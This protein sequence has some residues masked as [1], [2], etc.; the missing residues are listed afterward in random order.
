MSATST[1]SEATAAE[2]HQSR[3]TKYGLLMAALTNVQYSKQDIKIL[4][5]DPE[6]T[7]TDIRQLFGVLR[8]RFLDVVWDCK[9]LELWT[10]RAS[11][12]GIEYMKYVSEE[13]GSGSSSLAVFLSRAGRAVEDR[14]GWEGVD[15][16]GDFAACAVSSR[17]GGDDAD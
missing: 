16:C 3:Q 11:H 9:Q 7:D 12:F 5:Q 14:R 17:G 10:K 6:L 13:S 1:D 4:L 8:K 2:L 15:C